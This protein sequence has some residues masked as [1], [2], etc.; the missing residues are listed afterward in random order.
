M[1]MC[2]RR[3]AGG[4]TAPGLSF[5]VLER[6]CAVCCLCLIVLTVLYPTVIRTLANDYCLSRTLLISLSL[7]LCSAQIDC[8]CTRLVHGR[9]RAR[10]ALVTVTVFTHSL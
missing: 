6:G 9:R 5:H 3:R 4:T 2:R 8:S 7:S 1:E 10:S